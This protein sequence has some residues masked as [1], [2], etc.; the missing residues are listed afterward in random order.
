MKA[1]VTGGAGFIGSHLVDALIEEG[2]E[3]TVIDNL[4]TGSE[5][6]LNPR[7]AFHQVDITDFDAV[8][9]V[10]VDA[11]P[12]IVSHLAAQTSVRRSMEDP[13]HDAAVNILG[14][15][16]VLGACVEHD[17]DRFVFAST[18]AVYAGAQYLPMDEAHAVLPESA[19]GASKYAVEGYVRMFA[20]AYRLKYKILRYGN[21]FGPRQNPEGEAG[22]ISIFTM[23]F[24]EGT[25]PTIFGDGT[26]TRDY[27]YVGDI[28][29]GNLLAIGE[30]GDNETYNLAG[31]RE[32]TDFQVFEAVRKAAGSDMEPRYA[33]IRP[34]EVLK[35]CLDFS[36]AKAELGWTPKVNLEDGIRNVVTHYRATR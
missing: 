23:Q 28:V 14:S 36:K 2:H 31:G 35:S 21:V 3:V 11:K 24:I 9:A 32:I 19:Y 17:V 29:R 30:A 4:A 18:C 25:Q 12:Q 27:V 16:N 8:S 33:P 10:F 22:V 6:N 13:V 5:S 1:L 15:L 34:G 20:H 7:A 26:K